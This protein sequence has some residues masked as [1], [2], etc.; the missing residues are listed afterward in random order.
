[1]SCIFVRPGLLDTAETTII[2]Q[3]FLQTPSS[4]SCD[5]TPCR[6]R[7]ALHKQTELLAAGSSQRT[8]KLRFA[9]VMAPPPGRRVREHVPRIKDASPPGP[10]PVSASPRHDCTCRSAASTKSTRQ[11]L[12]AKLPSLPVVDC[13]PSKH[14]KTTCSQG[15]CNV[16][17]NQAP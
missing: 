3:A 5:T 10:T 1:M 16:A 15:K 11:V 6:T 9:P 4:G 8:G 13:R 2:Q 17:G 7:G 12:E 14:S